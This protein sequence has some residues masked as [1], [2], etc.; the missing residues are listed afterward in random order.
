M[1]RTATKN[2]RI[3]TQIGQIA[4]LAVLL[5]LLAQRGIAQTPI[6][7]NPWQVGGGAPYWGYVLSGDYIY[8]PDSSYLSIWH[9]QLGNEY[10]RGGIR[11]VSSNTLRFDGSRRGA[12]DV[13]RVDGGAIYIHSGDRY[14]FSAD[15]AYT[16]PSGRGTYVPRSS[17]IFENNATI[18]NGGAI[19]ITRTEV[20][21][22]NVQFYNNSTQPYGNTI[23][24]SGGG[25]IHNV[26]GNLTFTDAAF[27]AMIATPITG[28]IGNPSREGVAGPFGAGLLPG[29]GTSDWTG[30]LQTITPIRGNHTVASGGA[31]HTSGGS[32]T[33]NANAGVT[34]NADAYATGTS[35]NDYAGAGNGNGWYNDTYIPGV[36]QPGSQ[37]DT[38]INWNDPGRA[39]TVPWGRNPTI[40]AVS[41]IADGN[42][43]NG[44][45]DGIIGTQTA[46]TFIE[47]KAGEY[48]GAI[49]SI[50]TDMDFTAKAVANATANANASASNN[51]ND[52][53]FGNRISHDAV[54]YAETI[55]N[56][57]G[58]GGYFQDNE[59]KISGGAIYTRNGTLTFE[60]RDTSA[61]ARATANATANQNNADGYREWGEANAWANA[62]AYADA[63]A[64]YFLRNHADG[65]G[66][67]DGGGAI[68]N[69]NGT[70]NFIVHNVATSAQ[71]NASATAA[72]AGNPNRGHEAY[73]YSY[74]NAWAEAYGGYFESNT[75][76]H[77]GA[78]YSTGTLNFTAAGN[79]TSTSNSNA[80]RAS[81]TSATNPGYPAWA[82]AYSNGW[83]ARAYGGY[84]VDNV[85]R[86]GGAIYNDGGTFTALA[87][88]GV[89]VSWDTGNG[90]GGSAGNGGGS[91]YWTA[92]GTSYGLAA[93][94][95]TNNRATTVA[96]YGGHGGAI[97]NTNGGTLEFIGYSELTTNIADLDGGGI[98][99]DGGTVTV[100]RGGHWISNFGWNRA[101]RDGGAFYNT[102]DGTI[103]MYSGSFY[104]NGL[105][106]NVGGHV[107]ITQRGG[108]IF[109]NE[110]TLNLGRTGYYA[111]N[112]MDSAV[113][114]DSNSAEKTGGAIHNTKDGVIN[115]YGVSFAYNIAGLEGGA[116][117][118][119]GGE[120]NIDGEMRPA[121]GYYSLFSYNGSHD[122]SRFGTLTTVTNRGGAIYNT[123]D[124]SMLGKLN[125]D[126]TRFDF[127]RVLDAGGAIYNTA[128]G[129]FTLTDVEF[130]ENIAARQGGALWNAGVGIITSALFE[131]NNDSTGNGYQGGAVFNDVTGELT[132]TDS[133]FLKNHV[134]EAVG[135]NAPGSGGAIYNNSG[136]LEFYGDSTFLAN[137]AY[138]G[139]A[140][141]NNG[142]TIDMM[143]GGTF[144][145]SSHVAGVEGS[146]VA[147]HGGAIYNANGT[148]NLRDVVFESNEARQNGGETP[149]GGAIHSAGG[150]LNL[151]DV[152]FISNH[153]LGATGMG[154]A[155][156]NESGKI[157]LTV[158]AGSEVEFKDNR[159]GSAYE[160]IYFAG[161]GNAFDIDVARG[162]T[163]YMYDPMRGAAN[164]VTTIFQD[165]PGTWLLAGNNNFAGG[166]ADFTMDKGK[167][168]F[169]QHN[170]GTSATPNL[171][172]T[173][174]NLG[175]GTFTLGNGATL[176][177]LDSG[178][179]IAANN[180]VM[181]DG[182]FLAFHL[183]EA[184]TIRSQKNL[185]ALTLTLS[186][187]RD[188]TVD[189]TFN[190]DLTGTL[191]WWEWF[192]DK[193]DT[194]LFLI[195]SVT[196]NNVA[197]VYID[198]IK[199]EL[200]ERNGEYT[201]GL[202]VEKGWLK[203]KHDINAA[204]LTNY[205]TGRDEDT[206]DTNKE[207]ST[208][209]NNRN[210]YGT[211]LGGS[212]TYTFYTDDVVVFADRDGRGQTVTQKDVHLIENTGVGA[213]YVTGSGYYFDLDPGVT[214]EAGVNS[215]N[216]WNQ[217]DEN[218]YN[219]TGNITFAPTTGRAKVTMAANSVI[220]AAGDISFNATDI[221]FTGAATI[222]SDT[223]NKITI[224][225]TVSL[226][227]EHDGIKGGTFIRANEVH[228]VGGNDFY[229]DLSSSGYLTLYN[230]TGTAGDGDIHVQN[231]TGGETQLVQ[232]SGG[233]TIENTGTLYVNGILNVPDRNEDTMIGIGDKGT[234]G[235]QL[236]ILTVDATGDKENILL[237]WTGN[238]DSVW[239]TTTA[240]W[241]GKVQGITVKTFLP[242]DSVSFGNVSEEKKK[243]AI[244][245]I[246][247]VESMSVTAPGYRFE[248]IGGG[249]ITA[250][251][252]IN[253]GSRSTIKSA[254]GTA[255]ESGGLITFGNNTV[256]EFD[257]AGAT[258]LSPILKIDGGNGGAAIGGGIIDVL[259]N[260][261]HI[262]IGDSI[263][264]VEWTNYITVGTNNLYRNGELYSPE[265]VAGGTMYQLDV[266]DNSKLFL[267]GVDAGENAARLVWTGQNEPTGAAN[268]NWNTNTANKNWSGIVNGVHVNTF[269]DGDTVYFDNT[270]SHKT[271]VV[272]G[273][274]T[275]GSMFVE[276]KGIDRYTFDLRGGSIDAPN[277]TIELSDA[278]L[279]VG[280]SYDESPFGYNVTVSGTITASSIDVRG[281][282]LKVDGA[283]INTDLLLQ[284]GKQEIDI[285][286][287][288]N[289]TGF[290]NPVVDLDLGPFFTALFSHNGSRGILTLSPFDF[291]GWNHN[292][293]QAANALNTLRYSWDKEMFG[294]F[295]DKS[296]EMVNRLRG[297]ELVADSLAIPLWRPWEITHQRLRTVREE[298]G[299]NSWGE[300][301]YQMGKVNSNSNAHGFDMNRAGSMIGADY[302]ANRHWQVGGAFGY[303]VPKLN[304]T[305]G[306]VDADDVT[307][308]VYSKINFL[309]QAVIN[310]FLGY[311]HQNYK[312]R[313]KGFDGAVHRSKYSGDAGYASIELAQPVV[314]ADV[315]V[316]TPLV[317]LDHQA[318]WTGHFVESG[319]WGQ[320]LAGTRIGRTMVR[321]GLDTQWSH[322]GATEFLGI[323][324]IGTRL[325]VAFMAMGDQRASVKSFFPTTGASMNLRGADLGMVQ[326][327]V[328]ATASGE[329]MD[330]H[331]WFID[332][333]GFATEK[334]FSVQGHVGLTTRF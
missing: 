260:L 274:V 141:Y 316:I 75:A 134:S 54:A 216:D 247:N 295:F 318:A 317:A 188:I 27:G 52:N 227:T 169:L 39:N 305:F 266:A 250:V 242:H 49:Y 11:I 123:N 51:T 31:I 331:Y 334:M 132:F 131:G 177:L 330:K 209:S 197:N 65:T 310:T 217:S 60:A 12:A 18:G 151:T 94:Y 71:A 203:I 19:S 255:I 303:A 47:N 207:W 268:S 159:V 195:S 138:S 302:G 258:A 101:G 29:R 309:D 179:T 327:N 69:E 117:Y 89:G 104:A 168:Q 164:A 180:V 236:W 38:V 244:S 20:N 155:I 100:T 68:Y 333:D 222:G 95:F 293:K 249:K 307:L 118:N 156:Y 145:S 127:N 84:F 165:G 286:F 120:L 35:N 175:A 106:N 136:T 33:F 114:F 163:L 160:S 282:T 281:T 223:Q 300:G 306:T 90:G 254:N 125:I 9:L 3:L 326:L 211:G 34:I 277:G 185:A 45:F 97:Y 46:N 21:F 6:S 240:N 183:T 17:L 53:N 87:E 290:M 269:L 146:N 93:T 37:R 13:L 122:P 289:I 332:L 74:A 273:D 7:I 311:G 50:G 108:A 150:V 231:F 259:G 212:Y 5:C 143:G 287:A 25:A 283:G 328:G 272:N 126:N 121:G 224:G 189:S 149:S 111:N 237:Q 239:D 85:A 28:T 210:W 2:H 99:N 41:N 137:R 157:N 215:K 202:A 248:L 308:G 196:G 252:N 194:G 181:E 238:V 162:G 170:Y 219:A 301:Y 205:W 190:V 214:L 325:H 110:G 86:L 229:F 77:G 79:A 320:S 225:S 243:V 296:Q 284:D 112:G 204:G 124:G 128:G 82:D 313:R 192:N 220:R 174:L 298:T 76:R 166:R 178:S 297:T 42:P 48:G 10:Q 102:N 105:M 304:N 24:T 152:N 8:S 91:W 221:G 253:F 315:G 319:D 299:W 26:G 171:V 139:G 321:A 129:E 140:I 232:V 233:G 135:G 109:N 208:D 201:S 294:G 172:N 14:D 191:D 241:T 323:F 226:G 44:W 276:S 288:D 154:G 158:T 30:I 153:V 63:R 198:G 270:A 292:T 92:Y 245:N 228:F 246:V 147:L 322:A 62:D 264:L 182:S 184:D 176:E 256:F 115:L 186:P 263:L 200:K 1:S 312:M 78:I 173:S 56:A 291:T 148:L 23:L 55:I 116:I 96:G 265:R 81:A 4:V 130:I 230:V 329:Y 261:D 234:N 15:Y 22:S 251:N 58:Y 279:V 57:F 66:I 206:G 271:V 40:D 119:E 218:E 16:L 103:T 64:G 144:G 213:M 314:M 235:K 142:G 67:R 280:V 267:K 83:W 73:A 324:D 36:T 199:A 98:Y 278:V 133:Y 72:S 161:T 107:T 275:V 43:G 32:L 187:N 262:S 285:L 257:I 59:A 61:T 167:L 88:E 113:S 193:D 70:L 80:T